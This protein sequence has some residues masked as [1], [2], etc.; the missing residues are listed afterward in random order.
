MKKKNQ[1]HC[2]VT[3]AEV[4]AY[5]NDAF[6]VEEEVSA[7]E[8][9][10]EN[11]DK[12]LNIIEEIQNELISNKL[13]SKSAEVKTQVQSLQ[14]D[15]LFREL[16]YDE[17]TKVHRDKMPQNKNRR[18]FNYRVAAILLVLMG[19]IFLLIINN[20]NIFR[21]EPIRSFQ[22]KTKK[23]DLNVGKQE[24]DNKANKEKRNLDNQ[25]QGNQRPEGVQQNPMKPSVSQNSLDQK[26][27]KKPETDELEPVR[28][29]IRA[30]FE[31]WISDA[32][33]N[34]GGKLTVKTPEKN[35]KISVSNRIGGML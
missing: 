13:H 32:Q 3:S 10:M 35:E 8:E 26:N 15:F 21:K 1:E 29:E 4:Q 12:C 19:I 9:K 20:Q 27:Q 17:P 14:Q 11:C 6:K 30:N 34:K 28:V 18:L 2:C 33:I 16:A 25:N 7:F 31:N 24:A 5:M 23:K 22:N